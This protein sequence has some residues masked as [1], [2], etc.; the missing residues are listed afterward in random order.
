VNGSNDPISKIVYIADK[1]ERTRNYDSSMYI[2]L[3]MT[4]LNKAYQLV[5]KTQVKWLEK[6]GVQVG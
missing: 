6:E 5:K 3:A 4:D 1:C 2:N